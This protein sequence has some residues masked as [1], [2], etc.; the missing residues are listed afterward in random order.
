MKSKSMSMTIVLWAEIILAARF[1]F[2]TLPV[3]LSNMS[4]NFEYFAAQEKALI[5][6]S[7]PALFFLVAGLL[8]L[9]NHKLWK[10]AQFVAVGVTFLTTVVLLGMVKAAQGQVSLGYFIP[11]VLAVVVLGFL[12]KSKEG[13]SA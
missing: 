12:L 7:V 3:L 5:T 13:V 8:S 4:T 6:L 1:L 11:A 2:F 9:L 10:A